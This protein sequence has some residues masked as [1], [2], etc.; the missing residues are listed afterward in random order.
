MADTPPVSAQTPAEKVRTFPQAPGVYLMKDAAGAVI[1]IG[2]AKN[3]RSR[4]GHYFLAEAAVDPRTR[5][6]VKVIADIDY[7]PCETEVDALLK[8]ARLIKDVRPKFNKDLKDGK[9]FPYLQIRTR[10]EF[11]RVEITRTPRRRGVR[12]YGPFTSATNLRAAV[13]VLQK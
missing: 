6:L 4:A 12:L 7:I 13:Q 5:E 8:E 1:Y 10:E 2:K 3:L 11:P 9:S